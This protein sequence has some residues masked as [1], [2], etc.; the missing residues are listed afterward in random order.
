M[1][2]AGIESFILLYFLIYRFSELTRIMN[3][4]ITLAL[5]GLFATAYSAKPAN[6]FTSP[7]NIDN[8]S[9]T[10][11][12]DNL[13]T[14]SAAGSSTIGTAANP[15]GFDSVFNTT[16]NTFLLLGA[17]DPSLAINSGTNANEDNANVTAT[18]AFDID[19]DNINAGTLKLDF[20]YSFQGTD[21]FDQDSFF[22][23]LT[24]PSTFIPIVSQGDYGSG[25]FSDTIDISTLT[26]GT[27]TLSVDL[28]ESTFPGNSAAGF[29]N[30]A[31]SEVPTAVPFGTSTNTGILI[32][33]G[34]YAGS[35]YL[36][37]RKISK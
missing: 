37:R 7:F 3:K 10:L 25:S 17:D 6:A 5:L 29:D 9:F 23:T 30:I 2:G 19:A 34:L 36:K 13:G 31:I 18:Y 20:D 35:S 33:G 1:R 8:T 12:N 14:N 16:G 22:V 24:G 28:D 26:A 11:N 21:T 32:L 15:D 4:K 27:Y